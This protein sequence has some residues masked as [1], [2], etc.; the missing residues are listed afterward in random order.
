MSR[1]SNCSMRCWRR[2]VRCR[3]LEAIRRKPKADQKLVRE[4]V[5]KRRDGPLQ[6]FPTDESRNGRCAVEKAAGMLASKSLLVYRRSGGDPGARP[7]WRT[8]NWWRKARANFQVHGPA[9]LRTRRPH[10]ECRWP[11]AKLRPH[12]FPFRLT[13]PPAWRKLKRTRRPILGHPASVAELADALDL[14]SSGETR[15]G[16]SPPSRNFLRRAPYSGAG[17]SRRQKM[18]AASTKASSPRPNNRPL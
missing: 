3:S 17:R 4:E 15:G 11:D 8:S 5:R 16:S 7:A 12:E 2:L 18:T 9:R 1:R 13:C 6:Q 10:G 14:G